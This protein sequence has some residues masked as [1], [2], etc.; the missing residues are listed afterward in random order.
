M[1]NQDIIVRVV[2]MAATTVDEMVQ[3][4]RRGD[5]DQRSEVK[6]GLIETSRVNYYGTVLYKTFTF[7]LS[8]PKECQCRL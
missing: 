2:N 4:S 1:S 5:G 7:P 6:S 8:L 3:L